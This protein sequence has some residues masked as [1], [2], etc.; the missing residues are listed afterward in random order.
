MVHAPFI[1]KAREGEPSSKR[2]YQSDHEREREGV[3]DWLRS[4]EC[5]EHSRD[6]PQGWTGLG[7]RLG[8]GARLEGTGEGER[9][10][11]ETLTGLGNRLRLTSR[12]RGFLSRASEVLEGGW[13][14]LEGDRLTLELEGGS[15]VVS[16]STRGEERGWIDLEF[17]RGGGTWSTKLPGPRART[18]KSK[19]ACRLLDMRHRPYTVL[20][21]ALYNHKRSKKESFEG[22]LDA[23]KT[24]EREGVTHSKPQALE[25]VTSLLTLLN[26][27]RNRWG[28][29]SPSKLEPLEGGTRWCGVA[30]SPRVAS[31]ESSEGTREEGVLDGSQ[32]RRGRVEVKPR[33]RGL[34]ETVLRRGE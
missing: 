1:S 23:S 8:G 22:E 6:I 4:W 25:E 10:L 2:G 31:K 16:W 14:T 7:T 26:A 13:L 9:D 24:L 17:E 15:G 32:G 18:Q 11:R 5:L 33:S 19:R 34:L 29:A 12:A 21:R 27:T 3:R 30:R 20:E 28:Q